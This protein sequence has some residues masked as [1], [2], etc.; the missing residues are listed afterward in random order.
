MKQLQI[1]IAQKS[2][3]PS[4]VNL[5]SE[6]FAIE[7]DF[8]INPDKQQRGLELLFESNQAVIFVA[9]INQQIIGMCS[10]QILVSTAQGSKVGLIEDVIISKVYQNQGIGKQLLDF[11]KNWAFQQHLTRL[12]L[13]ADKNNQS[14][15]GFYQKNAWQSTQLI[16]LRF[17]L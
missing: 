6:L 1:R 3:I 15:L 11:V 17:L 5:L 12:Q 13:L 2:D 10:V 9:E 4:M 14:A 8:E 16:A 7:A